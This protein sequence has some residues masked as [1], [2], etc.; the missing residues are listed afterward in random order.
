MVRR[1]LIGKTEIST[2]FF[3]GGLVEDGRGESCVADVRR[4]AKHTLAFQW[5]GEV[6]VKSTLVRSTNLL[7]EGVR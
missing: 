7:G 5:E 2:V 3:C 4:R 1:Y 6:F